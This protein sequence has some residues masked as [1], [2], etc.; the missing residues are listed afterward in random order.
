M[1][2]ENSRRA[3]AAWAPANHPSPSG[4]G[5]STPAGRYRPGR[6]AFSFPGFYSCCDMERFPMRRS[7]LIFPGAARPRYWPR[8]Q[9]SPR[10]SSMGPIQS[11]VT[12][13]CWGFHTLRD[14]YRPG[15][16]AF[17]AP[18][19]S[20]NKDTV[21]FPIQRWKIT[22]PGRGGTSGLS[23]GATLAAC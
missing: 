22:L 23:R 14:K 11:A 16:S 5:V 21:E 6:S 10:A 1:P 2:G 20:C 18:G 3:W 9:L 7:T 12:Q 4:V 17:S 13:W 8:G 19:C 15:G